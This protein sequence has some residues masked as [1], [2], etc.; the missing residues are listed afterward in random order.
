MLGVYDTL[1]KA[2]ATVPG[3]DWE[4]DGND[5]WSGDVTVEDCDSHSHQ[6]LG[7]SDWNELDFTIKEVFVN[8]PRSKHFKERAGLVGAYWAES[9]ASAK[10]YLGLEEFTIFGEES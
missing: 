8:S 6:S 3:A 9:I 10:A 1:E 4:F 5:E 2:K 7:P